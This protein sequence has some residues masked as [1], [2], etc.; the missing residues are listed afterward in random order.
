MVD[1]ECEKYYICDI[2]VLGVKELGF[3]IKLDSA[4]LAGQVRVVDKLL[5][6]ISGRGV[7][8]KVEGLNNLNSSKFVGGIGQMNKGV[9]ELKKNL[10]DVVSLGRQLGNL[11]VNGRGGG[12]TNNGSRAGFG[13]ATGTR[14]LLSAFSGFIRG[15]QSFPSQIGA[16]ASG[17]GRL[18]VTAGVPIAGAAAAVRTLIEASKVTAEYSDKQAELA[19][20]L[21]ASR[22]STIELDL[23][24][25][26]L[27]E[28]MSFT[29]SQIAGAEIELA[30]LGF[31]RDE[32]KSIVEDVA[33]LSIVGGS[34]VEDS[35]ALTAQ[36]LNAFNL[37][38]SDSDDVVSALG[39]STA[40]T[41]AS[42]ETLRQ[43]ANQVFNTAN[44]FGLKLEETLALVGA[45]KDVGLSD[46][47]ATTATRNIL[48]NLSDDTG[49]LRTALRGLGVKDVKGLDGIVGSLKTLRAANIDLSE[50]LELTDKR[51]VNA[52]NA[53]LNGADSLTTLKD[54]ITGANEEFL[55]M[56]KERLNSL[57]G[58]L[59]L[60]RSK[61][62]AAYL[63]LGLEGFLK[64]VVDIGTEV[65]DFFS[66]LDAA[67]ATDALG[68]RLERFND[69]VNVLKA[70]NNDLA[71]RSKLI[72]EIS[73]KYGDYLE[74]IDLENLSLQQISDLQVEVAGKM[75]DRIRVVEG[76]DAFTKA[77]EIER[78]AVSEL[79][80]A[81][82][83]LDKGRRNANGN[84]ISDFATNAL[85]G[86]VDKSKNNLINAQGGVIGAIRSN[87]DTKK[88]LTTTEYLQTQRV[89]SE[90]RKVGSSGTRDVYSKA[91]QLQRDFEKE[92][93]K[94]DLSIN[95]AGKTNAELLG[96]IDK[97]GNVVEGYFTIRQREIE[98]IAKK[99]DSDSETR[100][101][102]DKAIKELQNKESIVRSK[103]P[104]LGLPKKGGDK[105][106]DG[107]AAFALGSIAYLEDLVKKA[108]DDIRKAGEGIDKTPLVK[109]LESVKDQLEAA[110]KQVE[111]LSRLDNKDILSQ[112]GSQLDNQLEN[113]KRA[114][115][116]FFKDKESFAARELL[117][118]K[119]VARTKLELERALNDDK[120][121]LQEKANLDAA[122]ETAKE[123]EKRASRA[124]EKDNERIAAERA[125]AEK[126]GKLNTE[127]YERFLE[128]KAILDDIYIAERIEKEI[129]A[130]VYTGDEKRQK[131]IEARGLRNKAA[132]GQATLN[133]SDKVLAADN[134]ILKKTQEFL[135]GDRSKKSL[136]EYNEFLEKAQLTREILSAQVDLDI[137]KAS[138][139]A[140]KIAE[141]TAKLKEAEGKLIT[142]AFED[143]EEK[144]KK[145]LDTLK[146]IADQVG[147]V[148][149]AIFDFQKQGVENESD[150]ELARID[151][152]YE[153]KLA[154]A[155][156]NAAEE[157]KIQ[158][159]YDKKREEAEV[160][161]ARKRKDIA[162]KEAVVQAALAII[163][164]AP[165]PLA[166]GTAVA[167]GLIQIATI[168]KQKF[169]RGGYGGYYSKAGV[170]TDETG[171][172]VD[173]ANPNYHAGEYHVK[174]KTVRRFPNVIRFLDQDRQRY[175]T[176]IPF[177]GGVGGNVD[178]GQ[179]AAQI[180]AEVAVQVYE[181]TRA[182]SA[183]GSREGNRDSYKLKETA[184][185]SRDQAYAL[186]SY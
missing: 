140:V 111:D 77:L 143:T 49:K 107:E 69:D 105:D 135:D 146:G 134:E 76:Q 118:E 139:N 41:A 5:K 106:K 162:L 116:V 43:G 82:T 99:Y 165:D 68:D 183:Q 35:A 40:K 13:P 30:K 50:S 124:I 147:S 9:L 33:R 17:V 155:K 98:A 131:E 142:N 32:I 171:E 117:L 31:R 73:F 185:M 63:G 177:N 133:G 74:G 153:A 100:S 15:G 39:V 128:E 92:F 34:S 19:S 104:T 144:G 170:R 37:S 94:I 186:N 157:E 48:L 46:S 148:F 166:I 154:N 121:S 127:D 123:E 112:S 159:E 44:A 12:G 29:A 64:G 62:E 10:T 54:S 75:K 175:G 59:V 22:D 138:G 52:F 160:K 91:L 2:K 66:K 71:L 80:D 122:I 79:K 24:A 168:K 149:G 11:N 27:G 102:A 172:Y 70:A 86:F 174:A 164:A 84:F 81:Y 67:S 97:A 113:D 126:L 16:L 53:F 3:R 7:T 93:A 36:T 167:L 55:I 72:G 145:L 26:R 180:G 65:L 136:K 114:L 119:R 109:S 78:L 169:A 173:P 83:D 181:A 14:S 96:S 151:A 150:N 47:V 156:G 18:G 4:G 115:A 85:S 125:Y 89:L 25:R 8:F 51:S 176:G 20:R 28:T 110:K 57:S 42:F 158:K 161:A 103:A 184:R 56:E 182:G 45:L 6:G 58:S 87:F 101:R 163:K 23:E 60:F 108:E 120:L 90:N 137:A 129:A 178:V 141:A 38:V 179:I 132:V 88:D 95:T 130:G 1:N 21:A 61:V 152:L